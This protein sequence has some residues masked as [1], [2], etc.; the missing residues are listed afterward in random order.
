MLQNILNAL[1]PHVIELI[2]AI[3]A[4]ILLPK[5]YTFLHISV[6]DSRKATIETALTNGI[7]YAIGKALGTSPT[8]PDLDAAKDS[9]ISIA[10][11]YALG[12]VPDTLAKLG[13]G[14]NDVAQLIEARLPAIFE[15]LKAGITTKTTN[16]VN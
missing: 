5:L 12:R 15:A 7:Q 6:D 3:F 10:S 9:I 16:V 4:T 8:A 14:D 2:V 1:A 13:L 11:E